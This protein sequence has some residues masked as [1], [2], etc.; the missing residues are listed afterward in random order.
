MTLL[1]NKSLHMCLIQA[2]GMILLRIFQVGPQGHCQ[3]PYERQREMA[4]TQ[5]GKG[6]GETEEEREYKP[7]NAWSHQRL[8]EEREI[9]PLEGT[10]AYQQLDLRLQAS[11]SVGE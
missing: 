4:G 7:E 10:G 5:K 1:G 9:L 11:R 6:E 2:H 8:E 3:G